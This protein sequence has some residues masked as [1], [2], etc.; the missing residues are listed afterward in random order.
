MYFESAHDANPE[1]TAKIEVPARIFLTREEV[2]LCPPEY[3][4]RSYADFSYGVAERGGH[5]LAAEEPELLAD[6]IRRWFRRF[7]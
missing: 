5:F 7:R 6:D 3:A 4:A 1:N 2:D